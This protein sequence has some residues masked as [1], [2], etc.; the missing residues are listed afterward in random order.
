MEFYNGPESD[1]YAEFEN[2]TRRKSLIRRRKNSIFDK[3]DLNC[4]FSS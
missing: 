2:A 3:M 4:N 1:A